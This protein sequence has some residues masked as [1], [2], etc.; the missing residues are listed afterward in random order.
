MNREDK[1][2]RKIRTEC[3]GDVA[4]DVVIGFPNNTPKENRRG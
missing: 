4:S 3:A 1:G 2:E